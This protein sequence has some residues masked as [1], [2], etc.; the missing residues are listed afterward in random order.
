L[1]TTELVDHETRS[2]SIPFTTV[3]TTMDSNVSDTL[4]AD[5]CDVVDL[6]MSEV[7]ID[8]PEV[9]ASLPPPDQFA[10]SGSLRS[11]ASEIPRKSRTYIWLALAGTALIAIIIG[12][13]VGLT[14]K[15]VATGAS[16]G[17]SSSVEPR[18]ATLA[19]AIEYFVNSN[20]SSARDL[21]N[22]AAPQAKA[23]AWIAEVDGR[24]LPVPGHPISSPVGYHYLSRFVMGLLFFALDGENWTL[25][26]SWL[27]A[28]DFCSWNVLL[29]GESASGNQVTVPLGAYCDKSTRRILAIHLGEFVCFGRLVAFSRFF[30]SL[31]CFC[32]PSA[33]SNNLIGSIPKELAH[34]GECAPSGI[35][36]RSR[37]SLLISS[38]LS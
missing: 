27:S 36:K 3:R 6:T 19:A 35:S 2:R 31:F 20:V 9:A 33:D 24:N 10:R 15:S 28:D 26:P 32:N 8:S 1:G 38:F 34:L 21:R 30:S 18:K 11:S 23:I 17:S 37:G 7:P 22:P 16:Q 5:D 12:L 4:G 13:S 25:N 29:R 14:G